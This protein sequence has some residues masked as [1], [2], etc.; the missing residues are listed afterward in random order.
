MQPNSLGSMELEAFKTD[1]I[2]N[3]SIIAHVGKE[4]QDMRRL[5]C[6]HRIVKN[7]FGRD[8]LQLQCGLTMGSTFFYRYR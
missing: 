7:S 1:Q 6:R 2:R 4:E 5:C 8:S 3:F